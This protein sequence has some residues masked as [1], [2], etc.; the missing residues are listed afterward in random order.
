MQRAI[1]VQFG[2]GREAAG[3]HARAQ[4]IDEAAGMAFPNVV[5]RR[6]PAERALQQMHELQ[7]RVDVPEP[8]RILAVTGLG[9]SRLRDEIVEAAFA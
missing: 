7:R 1:C 4:R 2:H 3:L 8:R 6:E 5:D 9:R